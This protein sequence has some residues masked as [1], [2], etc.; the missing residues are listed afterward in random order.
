MSS[1]RSGHE[2]RPRPQAR[3]IERR[4]SFGTGRDD[5]RPVLGHQVTSPFPEDESKCHAAPQIDS[6]AS[7]NAEEIDSE[8]YSD[9]DTDTASVT[10]CD[11]E[12]IFAGGPRPEVEFLGQSLPI[13]AFTEALI[14][15]FP[16]IPAIWALP[17]VINQTGAPN[18]A[19]D[20]DS[21][22][23][24]AGSS[25]KDAVSHTQKSATN[26]SCGK[27]PS[28]EMGRRDGE[29][30]DGNEEERKRPKTAGEEGG[31]NSKANSRRFACPYFKRDPDKYRH[32][33][34]C[35]GP[36]WFDL[37]RLKADHLF[38]FHFKH[39]CLRCGV[40][41]HDKLTWRAHGLLE[42]ACQTRR[43]LEPLDKL[44]QEQKDEL[45]QRGGPHQRD[46][47]KWRRIYR[48]LFPD[49]DTNI[50]PSPYYDSIG[51]TSYHQ[52]QQRYFLSF[53]MN[54]LEQILL[55]NPSIRDEVEK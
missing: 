34:W 45:L 28:G 15:Q 10:S 33:K 18:R 1:S 36:G 19:S 35:P 20:G 8:E 43:P 42:P 51:G 12:T 7:L 53:F 38:K 23:G 40:S 50:E 24:E 2:M 16:S 54:G 3:P 44:H 30:E 29:E 27:R 22:V 47:Q 4:P 21:S 39:R 17:I 49:D 11:E 5:I 52:F 32:C 48:I 37:H 46:E 31:A 26:K 13:R 55:R 9:M 14:T 41:F 6:E 25:S